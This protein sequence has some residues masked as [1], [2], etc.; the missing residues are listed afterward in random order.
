MTKGKKGGITYMVRIDTT[1]RPVRPRWRIES[2][3]GAYKGLQGRGDESE[4]ASF[5]VSTLTGKVWR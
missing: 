2:A 5:S 1:R 3:T 4:N